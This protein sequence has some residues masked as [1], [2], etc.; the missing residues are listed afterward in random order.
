MGEV[1]PRLIHH[2]KLHCKLLRYVSDKAKAGAFIDNRDNQLLAG[3]NKITVNLDMPVQIETRTN[4]AVAITR[5]PLNFAIELSFNQTT[6]IGLR[7]PHSLQPDQTDKTESYL[8]RSA[9]ALG[10]VKRLFP[11]APTQY[12]TAIHIPI[13]AASHI[14]AV[15]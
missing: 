15:D 7:Y 2:L 10:D 3:T 11:N 13:L 8:F 6:T 4:G 12:L 1:L 14:Y 5:G 9:Q